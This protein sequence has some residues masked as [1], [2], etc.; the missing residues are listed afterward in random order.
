MDRNPCTSEH[1]REAAPED[2]CYGAI[3][4]RIGHRRGS[5]AEYAFAGDHA[6]GWRRHEIFDAV[7]N[8]S[9]CRVRDQASD[10]GCSMGLG[11]GL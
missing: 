3:V 6:R 4:C 11:W 7:E 5:I 8:A 9:N 10:E 2:A 1:C